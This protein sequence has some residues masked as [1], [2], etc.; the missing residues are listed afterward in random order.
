MPELC[1]LPPQGGV[2]FEEQRHKYWWRGQFEVE[3]P[4][5][6]HII[7]LSGA[8]DFDKTPWQRSLMR[9]GLDE[10]EAK[11]FM[12]QVRVIRAAIGTRFHAMAGFSLSSLQRH[13]LYPNYHGDVEA[14]VIHSNWIENVYPRIGKVYIIE[15]PMIHLNGCYGFTPDLVAEIDGIISICDWKSSQAERCAERYQRLVEY[16]PA[17]RPLRDICTRLAAADAKAGRTG[18]STARVRGGWQAQQGAYAAGVEFVGGLRV[19]RGIN[20]MLSV[21]GIK[22]HHWNRADLVQG[23]LQFAQGLFLHHQRAAMAGNAVFRRALE[24]MHR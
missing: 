8:K 13:K 2:F 10:A 7:E 24:A 12:E 19:E 6:S 17:D 5:S 11:Y 4:S 18:G 16:A 20:F 21:D 23:W 1:L 22:E 14:A 3:V 15:R 9:K